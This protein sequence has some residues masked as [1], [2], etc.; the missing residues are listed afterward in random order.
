MQA[1]PCNILQP[2][3]SGALFGYAEQGISPLAGNSHD[4]C[5]VMRINH[6]QAIPSQF[7]ISAKNGFSE[8]V[9]KLPLVLLNNGLPSLKLIQPPE[10]MPFQKGK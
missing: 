5:N 10:N 9:P 8:T 7:F 3:V 1:D 6:E 2:L 4:T